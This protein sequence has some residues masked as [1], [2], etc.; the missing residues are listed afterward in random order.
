MTDAAPPSRSS[1]SRLS[2]APTVD[3]SAVRLT[4]EAGAGVDLPRVALLGLNL[5]AVMLAIPMLYAPPASSG[6]LRFMWLGAPLL[7]LAAGTL[8]LRRLHESAMWLLIAVYPAV[9]AAVIAGRPELSGLDAFPPIGLALGAVSLAAFGGAAA[10]AVARPRATRHT[11]RQPLAA[12]PDP[13]PGAAKRAIARWLLLGAG[14]IGALVLV[15]IA[16]VRGGRPGAERAWG[17]AA[18][19]GALL[20]VVAGCALG[21]VVLS[22]FIGPALRASRARTTPKGSLRRVLLALL[23]VAS[24]V[25]AYVVY[26]GAR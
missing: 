6:T 24:G 26:R 2:G 25:V 18:A 17:D 11:T 19:E 10:A 15:A 22:V 23:V 8:A 3:A 9:V 21:T 1:E 14:A 4:Q 13:P 20:A 7:V 16:P 5:W 12:P